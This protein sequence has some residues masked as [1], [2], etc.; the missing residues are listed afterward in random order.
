[1]RS[2]ARA[3]SLTNTEKSEGHET[4]CLQERSQFESYS[5][6]LKIMWIATQGHLYQSERIAAAGYVEI[7]IIVQHRPD[8]MLMPSGDHTQR[9]NP[10]TLIDRPSHCAEKHHYEIKR[11]LW[12]RTL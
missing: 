4:E 9:F 2:S 10:L 6:K 11:A 3:L 12:K 1:M 8:Q 7:H 5:E